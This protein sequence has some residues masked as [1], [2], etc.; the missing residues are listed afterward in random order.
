MNHIMTPLRWK[1]AVG[2]LVAFVV[3]F[4]LRHELESGW[5]LFMTFLAPLSA[6]I[7]ALVALK[8][9][10]VLA[11]LTTF[12]IVS[13][14]GLLGLVIAVSK[15]GV[16]KGLFLPWLMAGLHWLHRRSR[17][18]QKWVSV[19]Y[20][21]GKSIAER[22]YGWWS[23]KLLIDKIL[24]AGFLGP[25]VVIVLF[26]VLLKRFVY[27][28]ISKKA[29]EQLVQKLTKATVNNFHKIPVVGK[30][31][32]LVKNKVGELKKKSDSKLTQA[33]KRDNAVD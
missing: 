13:L 17:F 30:A 7:S 4:I 32:E 11:A 1:I 19:A 25:L 2:Y 24:L 15:M 6:F 21:K 8:F 29:A 18:L 14:Q 12:L 33:R 31:P 23:D 3:T 16:I 5:S 26:A 20:E 22:L 9:G 10:V 28:F 27:M